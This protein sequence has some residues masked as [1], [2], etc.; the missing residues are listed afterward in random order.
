MTPPTEKDGKLAV[1]Q[2]V[3]CWAIVAPDAPDMVSTRT[4]AATLAVYGAICVAVVATVLR[5]RDVTS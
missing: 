4:A 5:R 1:T 2:E 3:I